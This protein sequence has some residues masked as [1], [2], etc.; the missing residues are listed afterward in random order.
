MRASR[1]QAS[2][3]YAPHC[4]TTVVMTAAAV[5]V[6]AGVATLK[7]YGLCQVATTR[8]PFPDAKY[9][10]ASDPQAKRD[11]SATTDVPYQRPKAL[12]ASSCDVCCALPGG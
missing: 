5:P 1:H 8:M 12:M 4:I 7:L 10:P 11:H 2:A 6:P 3:K 9:R